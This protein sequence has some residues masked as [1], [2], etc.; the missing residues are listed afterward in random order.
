MTPTSRPSSVTV[1]ARTLLLGAL[2]ATPLGGQ[3]PDSVPPDTVPFPLR[4]LEVRVLR[5][6][7]LLRDAPLAVSVVGG[8]Q[9]ARARPGTSL[10]A[11]LVAVP[12]VQVDDR[13]N[14]ALGE[15][16]A[17]RG[18]GARA[19]FGVRGVRVVVDGIPATFAD[20]QSA[21]SHVDPALLERVEVI[22]GPASALWG[23]AAGGVLLLETAGPGAGPLSQE[24][25]ISGGAHGLL[26]LES[27]TRG[28]GWL[29]GVSRRAGDGFRAWSSYEKRMLSARGR[30]AAAGG[31]LDASVHGV[32]YDARNPGSLSA[33]QRAEDR[34]GAHPF[35]VTQRTGEDGRQGQ[36]GVR[37]RGPLRGGGLEVAAF[38]IA[39][40]ISNPIP[41]SIID[42]DRNAGGVRALWRSGGNGAERVAWSVG[43]EGEGQWDDRR[44]FAN[45]GG[46]RGEPQLDQAERVWAGSAFGQVVLRPAPALAVL[47]G[48]RGD[49][50]SFRARDRRPA[51]DTDDSG[52]RVMAALSPSLG[53]SVDAAP[54]LLLYGNAATAF[55]TPTTTELAN[56]PS[57]AGGFNPELEPQRTLSLEVGTRGQRGAALGW[58]LA[59]YR[60][61]VEDALIPFEVPEAAGRQFF[62]NAGSAVHRGAELAVAGAPARGV[63]AQVSWTWTDARFDDYATADARFDGNRVP[64]VA[65]HRVE[66]ALTVERAGWLVG[67]EHRWQDETPVDD[68]NSAVSGAYH[69]TGL[70]A[71]ARVPARRGL[72]LE[73]YAGVSNV[74][75][76][77]Y[78][79]SVVVNAFGRRYYEP[80]P[81]RSLYGGLRVRF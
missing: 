54:W 40:R 55:E 60:A 6:P 8:A 69:L 58:E 43:V 27:V 23:N 65:P 52:T 46:E 4:P 44:T 18:F 13:H 62:R 42:L 51:G 76:R 28:D 79:A 32:D 64:G 56:R 7:T 17:I 68:A 16:I 50:L 57:G 30:V 61:R 70:R 74:L 24:L 48:L 34:A 22:R 63:L 38:G 19:Q 73:P 3:V 9:V 35:N 2:L 47:G 15:R 20:G 11:A 5:Q 10:R 66:G 81:G 71:S 49:R 39:R 77:R 53:V 29:L 72:L 59:L 67:V 25:E 31:V 41:P 36:L 21:L 12:G 78:D 33:E 1:T 26:R 14:E 75:D 80:G 37:W 45:E